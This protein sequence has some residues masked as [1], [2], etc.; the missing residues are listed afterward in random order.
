MGSYFI[1]RSCLSRGGVGRNE[2]KP[3]TSYALIVTIK[4]TFNL[5]TFKYM[6]LTKREKHSFKTV[7]A[8]DLNTISHEKEPSS[9]EKWQISGPGRASA[10]GAWMMMLSCRKARMRSMKTRHAE[11]T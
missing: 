8:Q 4:G 3:S 5:Y 9:L 2:A 11:R 6:R 1:T 7:S 10:E